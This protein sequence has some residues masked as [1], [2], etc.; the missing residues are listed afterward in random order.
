M[1]RSRLWCVMSGWSCG[2]LLWW[3]SWWSWVQRAST[4]L[5]T[6]AFYLYVNTLASFYLSRIDYYCTYLLWLSFMNTTDKHLFHSLKDKYSSPVST[7]TMLPSICDAPHLTR[8]C[9]HNYGLPCKVTSIGKRNFIFH[10]LYKA[11]YF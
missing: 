9:V 11:H 4:C 6:S 2:W 5:N 10:V 8:A 1:T 7:V 3:Q